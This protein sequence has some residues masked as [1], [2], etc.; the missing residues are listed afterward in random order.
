MRILI[1]L[2]VFN[3]IANAEISLNI[4]TGY[5]NYKQKSMNDTLNFIRSMV[6][7][8]S[9]ARVDKDASSSY[10]NFSVTFYYKSKVFP[11]G[12]S[13]ETG[14]KSTPTVGYNIYYYLP[15]NFIQGANF[16]SQRMKSCPA[17]ELIELNFKVFIIPISLQL[18][19]PISFAKEKLR[20]ELSGGII[21]APAWYRESFKSLRSPSYDYTYY[22]VSSGTGSNSKVNFEYC[23]DNKTSF[24]IGFG[25]Q[26]LKIT[27]FRATIDGINYKLFAYELTDKGYVIKPFVADF[28]GIF[29][30]TGI[31]F[32]F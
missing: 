32:Y 21:F 26:V 12:W 7:S 10:E 8:N 20:I 29:I 13:L 14:Y 2:L 5:G 31:K 25:Y 22:F 19:I 6:S 15:G 23:I 16:F 27:N 4:N 3:I 17:D 30:N 11:I 9:I 24:I 1:I 28:S 18:F